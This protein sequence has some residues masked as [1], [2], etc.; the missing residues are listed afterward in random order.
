MTP[1]PPQHQPLGPT[2]RLLRL[3]EKQH[4]EPNVSDILDLV[5]E[6]ADVTTYVHDNHKQTILHRLV[7][8]GQV[9]AVEACLT[10]SRVINLNLVDDRERTVFHYL[11]DPP[12]LLLMAGDYLGY[13]SPIQKGHRDNHNNSNSSSSSSSSSGSTRTTT[14]REGRS[15]GTRESGASGDAEAGGGSGSECSSTCSFPS[16]CPSENLTFVKKNDDLTTTIT[17]ATATGTGVRGEEDVIGN[18]MVLCTAEE[19]EE[20]EHTQTHTQRLQS[21]RRDPSTSGIDINDNGDDVS[22]APDSRAGPSNVSGSKIDTAAGEEDEGEND[23]VIFTNV[24]PTQGK[25]LVRASRL[26]QL[27]EREENSESHEGSKERKEQNK[28]RQKRGGRG[29]ASSSRRRSRRRRST[30]KQKESMEQGED[31][32]GEEEAIQENDRPT[33]TSIAAV[34]PTA[35]QTL[36]E[37][38]PPPSSAPLLVVGDPAASSAPLPL[39]CYVPAPTLYDD[40]IAVSLLRAI[41]RR[42]EAHPDDIRVD[43]SQPD[44]TGR[45]FI[46][47]AAQHQRLSLFYPEVRDL[48]YYADRVQPLA[49][50]GS[51]GHVWA[52]DLAALSEADRRDFLVRGGPDV[53]LQASRSTGQLIRLCRGTQWMPN[54][55]DMEPLVREGMADVC[56]KAPEMRQSILHEMVKRSNVEGVRVLLMTAQPLDFSTVERIDCS[57]GDYNIQIPLLHYICNCFHGEAIAVAMLKLLVERVNTH[58]TDHLDWGQK[59]TNGYDIIAQ[60]VYSQRLSLFWPLLKQVSYFMP[61]VPC[62]PSAVPSSHISQRNPPFTTRISTERVD[63]VASSPDV[64]DVPSEEPELPLLTPSEEVGANGAIQQGSTTGGTVWNS[65]FSQAYPHRIPVHRTIHLTDWDKLDDADKELFN[66]IK[67]F[68]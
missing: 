37:G 6:G 15:N 54:P 34:L 32:I 57:F 35:A 22:P 29:T 11:C 7:A 31:G 59:N 39:Y 5:R 49:L 19:E 9:G 66:P 45:D 63:T 4:W 38:P 25:A 50:G 61:P 47:L 16:R 60:V 43:F 14:S 55:E 58:P 41:V 53:V 62:S 33:R 51:G 67:G 56:F 8:H 1:P 42:I 10:T 23:E 21:L 24:N 27:C 18:R 52:W 28:Q 48:P 20:R 3:C 2:T 17:T 64:R 68:Q 40:D 44:W 13:P 46:A 30:K 26:H 65:A 12:L 36:G